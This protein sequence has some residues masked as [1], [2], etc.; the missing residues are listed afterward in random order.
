MIAFT[1]GKTRFSFRVAGVAIQDGCV[2]LHR[3]ET[4]DFWALPGGHVELMETAR[5]T[6]S[7]EMK[8]EIGL[9]VTVGRLLWV[10]ENF[11][12]YQG[13]A[14]H[15]LGLHFSMTLPVSPEPMRHETFAGCEERLR[16]IFRWFPLEEL[17]EAPI[18]P[19]FLR[20]SLGALPE[21]VQHIVQRD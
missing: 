5:D 7:R 10:V 4:D 20:S 6:L 13:K 2:L 1:Q 16:L 14:N 8:E 19:G 11:F 15:E 21:T 18:Y 17:P 9:D 3:F 12:D